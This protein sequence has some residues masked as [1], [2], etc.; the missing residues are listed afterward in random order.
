MFGN[1][2]SFHNTV[3]ESKAE[4][5]QH[6][7][8]LTISTPG[9]RLLIMVITLAFLIIGFWLYFGDIKQVLTSK[10]MLV[11]VDTASD[12][13]NQLKSVEVYV[14][15]RK[16]DAPQIIV[17]T[18]ANLICHGESDTKST[19]NGVIT[20]I[21]QNTIMQPDLIPVIADLSGGNLHKIGITLV[22][23][24]N[25][26]SMLDKECQIDFQVGTVSPFQ[27]FLLS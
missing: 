10:A 22:D 3:A 16:E 12:S 4:R 18:P 26:A 11:E 6:D 19:H 5:D 7:K 2:N 27:Y 23:K 1:L 13:D 20:L 15:I 17:G 25:N 21:S 9:E 14:W 24:I 8:L